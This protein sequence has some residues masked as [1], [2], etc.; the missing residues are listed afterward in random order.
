[1][2]VSKRW[3]A[4]RKAWYS[5]DY[6]L[7]EGTRE[8]ADVRQFVI[9]RTAVAAIDGQEYH[10]G[11]EGL[12]RG[13]FFISGTGDRIATAAR[14]NILRHRYALSHDGHD[15]E[16]RMTSLFR[17]SFGLFEKEKEIGTIARE[18]LFSGTTIIKLPDDLPLS[19][20]VFLFWLVLLS[21]HR[22]SR[23]R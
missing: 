2:R 15:Y 22:R 20:V 8:I 11:S 14:P 1:M 12:V 10:M 23:M 5:S 17:G 21:R 7:T 3:R 19:I 13:L 6:V 9:R 16:L 4:R 18:G